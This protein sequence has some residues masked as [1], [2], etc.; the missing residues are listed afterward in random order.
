MI[1][2]SKIVNFIDFFYDNVFKSAV[3]YLFKIYHGNGNKRL[4]LNCID[5]A[6]LAIS[7]TEL[8]KQI[9]SRKVLKYS[10][11]YIYE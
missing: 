8:A 5:D 11:K 1:A 7:A 2:L 6:I 9:R 10:L 4:R 3:I